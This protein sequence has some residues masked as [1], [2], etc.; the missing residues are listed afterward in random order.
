MLPTF[1]DR[2]RIIKGNVNQGFSLAYLP[3]LIY[4]S[5]DRAVFTDEEL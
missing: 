3:R 4:I 2:L 1:R 5:K